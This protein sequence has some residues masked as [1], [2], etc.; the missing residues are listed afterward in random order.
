MDPK[1]AFRVHPHE[2]PALEVRVNFG[3]YTGRNATAAEI[4]DL[5]HSLRTHV[6]TF[7]VTAEERHQFGDDIETS[8][9]QVV[10][11]VDGQ[12]AG[13]LSDDICERILELTGRWA[14]ACIASRSELGELGKV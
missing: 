1:I 10:I 3:V 2:E 13:A 9:H 11:E 12:S 7:T 8:L 5:A 4:D 6:P 14:A